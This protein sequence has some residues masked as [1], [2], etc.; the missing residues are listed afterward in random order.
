MSFGMFL[1]S[2]GTMAAEF[3]IG[4]ETMALSVSGYLVFTA[5][6]QLI[7]GPLADRYG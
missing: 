5:I 2:L 3:E 7:I 1:P 4:Y 6:L